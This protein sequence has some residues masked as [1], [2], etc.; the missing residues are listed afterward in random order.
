[1]GFFSGLLEIFFTIYFRDISFFWNVKVNLVDLSAGI[2]SMH[3]KLFNN[4]VPDCGE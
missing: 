3:I 4:W 2:N 1:M